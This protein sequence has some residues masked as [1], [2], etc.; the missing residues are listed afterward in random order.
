HPSFNFNFYGLRVT[1]RSALP[2]FSKLLRQK[3]F[4]WQTYPTSPLVN[5][6]IKVRVNLASFSLPKELTKLSSS[7][8]YNT[9]HLLIKH[10][11]LSSQTQI[12]YHFEHRKLSGIDLNLVTT[13]QFNLLNFLLGNILL[14]Q[15]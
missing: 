13:W 6:Q 12:V 15:L 10:Q 11:Y 14:Q 7:V 5:Q 3:F 9:E 1:C 4:G 2:Y 8:S